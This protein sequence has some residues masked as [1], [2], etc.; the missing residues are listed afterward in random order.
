MHNY[1]WEQFIYDIQ[2]CVDSGSIMLDAGAGN[3]H[4]K[5]YF[6][7]VR[8][9]A[10]DLGI[11]DSE[12]DYSKLDIRGDLRNIP[13]EDNSIDIII[14]IQV[15]EHLPE[16]WKVIAEFQRV[17]KPQGLLFIS[18]P[19]SEQQHQIPFDFFRYTP[20]GIKS[21][22]NSSGFE[23]V[24]IKSQLGNFSKI[25]NDVC[26][27]AKKLPSL[28]ENWL[29]KPILLFTSFYLRQVMWRLHQPLFRYLDRFEQFQDH[30]VGHFLK[31]NKL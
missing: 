16:P 28:S 25:M 7:S 10:M 14:S 18:C 6:P 9:I 3:C 4:W 21:L 23:V 8:Y 19:E 15:L 12:C 1:Y 20:F 2:S 17:L 5:S 13:L 29:L 24:W 30:S 26:Y 31:A 22:L 11:G 27:S